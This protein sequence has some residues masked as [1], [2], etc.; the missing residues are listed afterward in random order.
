MLASAA[1]PSL[2][3][4]AGLRLATVYAL[5]FALS[6]LAL[7]FFL[8][9]STAGLIDRQTEA[10]IHADAQ[11]LSEQFA[12]GGMAALRSTIEDRV[13]ENVDDDALYLLVNAQGNP[14]AG[15]LQHWPA[16][17][18]QVET[19]YDLRIE[20]AGLDETARVHR[21]DL[22]D[23]AHLLIGRDIETRVPLRGLVTS[24]VLWSMLLL[25][26]LA[27]AGALV[28]QRL[29]RRMIASVSSTATAVAQGDL[30]RRVRVTGSGDEFDRLA[31]SI[32]DM[33]DRIT[34]LMDGVRQVSNSIAHDL[35]TPIARARARLEDAACSDLGPADLRAVVER[36]VV[37]LDGIAAIFSALLR[38]AEIEAGTRRSAFAPVDVRAL[39]DD[40]TELYAAAAEEQGVTFDT[41]IPAGP[42]MLNGDRELI[43]QAVANLLDNA[44]KFSPPGGNIRLSATCNPLTM[45]IMVADNG[46][47]IPAADRGR[48]TERFFRGETARQ[49]PGYGLGLAL[50]D[51]V[52]QLHGGSLTLG[53]AEP[54]LQAVV[55]LRAGS[56]V[57]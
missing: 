14:V 23:G 54:G 30:S 42:L 43:G 3:R 53:D 16:A 25:V 55:A 13:A 27:T 21:Y 38:I 10:A 9:W 39:L 35:R 26:V 15:N 57:A 28:M 17:V 24:A 22:P 19:P 37:D 6:A 49:S 2:L 41:S 50:V 18:T 1:R 33:L 47:G 45:N 5:L 12:S 31:E 44:I 34:R 48:A 7:V 4:S 40:M 11:G 32:N 46:P 29:F 8:W 52:A 20:R 36:A 51:A 56:T